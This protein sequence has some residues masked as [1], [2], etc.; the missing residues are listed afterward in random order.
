MVAVQLAVPLSHHTHLFL[1][2]LGSIDSGSQSPALISTKP[3]LSLLQQW[4]KAVSVAVVFKGS[5]RWIESRFV[6]QYLAGGVGR[7]APRCSNA[8]R[9]TPLVLV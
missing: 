8:F 4:G 7:Q 3:S 6:R 2:V 5:C 9:E 1:V